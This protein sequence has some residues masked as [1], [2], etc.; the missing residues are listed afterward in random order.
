[1][2]IIWE[3]FPSLSSFKHGVCHTITHNVKGIL[4]KYFPENWWLWR[5]VILHLVKCKMCTIFTDFCWYMRKSTAYTMWDRCVADVVCFFFTFRMSPVG[6]LYISNISQEDAGMYECS[7]VNANGHTRAQG[8]LTVKGKF[9]LCK[10]INNMY[11]CCIF[12]KWAEE[13]IVLKFC[14]LFQR[15][16]WWVLVTDLFT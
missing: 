11:H 5:G 7:A 6:S 10:H 3:F 14:S 8:R 4:C 9:I 12:S 16:P 15:N 2:N 1:M 13:I